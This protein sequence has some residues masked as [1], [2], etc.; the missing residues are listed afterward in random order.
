MDTRV[1]EVFSAV[2]NASCWQFQEFFLGCLVMIM[3]MAFV[4]M[5]TMNLNWAEEAQ[6]MEPDQSWADEM[7]L[8]LSQSQKPIFH[9]APQVAMWIS[10]GTSVPKFNSLIGKFR[11][12][13]SQAQVW[14][15]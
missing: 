11:W 12:E 2:G 10:E 6:I 15:C 4:L 1:F 9:V 5:V 7:E 13:R 3:G 8:A 14:L